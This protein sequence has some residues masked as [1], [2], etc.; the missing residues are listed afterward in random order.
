MHARCWERG[1]HRRR[2]E[3]F[4]RTGRLALDAAAGE[5]ECEHGEDGEEDGHG[6]GELHHAARSAGNFLA[7]PLLAVVAVHV[8]AD[9]HV[10]DLAAPGALDAEA[11]GLHRQRMRR[12]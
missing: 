4:D 6:S 12:G 7:S 10:V 1:V 3:R 5:P 2:R 9:A 11:Q 8:A